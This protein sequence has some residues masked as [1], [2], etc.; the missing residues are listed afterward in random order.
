MWS[1]REQ[2]VFAPVFADSYVG[3]FNLHLRSICLNG[4]KVLIVPSPRLAAAVADAIESSMSADNG[5]SVSTGPNGS[6]QWAGPDDT[7]E[8]EP[9]TGFW[10]RFKAGFFGLLPIEKYL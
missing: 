9:E 5:W 1:P 10:L 7:C 8:Q 3:S 2:Q 6:L 4:E